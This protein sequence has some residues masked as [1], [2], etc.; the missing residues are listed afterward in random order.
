MG[1]KDFAYGEPCADDNHTYGEYVYQNNATCFEDGTEM[2]RCVNPYCPAKLIRSKPNTQLTHNPIKT[3]SCAPTCYSHGYSQSFYQCS[4]CKTYFSSNV[5]TNENILTDSDIQNITIPKSEDYHVF[6]SN[7]T[8]D[9]PAGKREEGLKSRHCIH[10]SKCY[11]RTDI[12]VIPSITDD[13]SW[14]KPK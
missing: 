6:E 13:D 8:I 12:T 5:T 11:G 9:I 3:E 2:A 4:H 14:G 10:Y 1:C 7:Y